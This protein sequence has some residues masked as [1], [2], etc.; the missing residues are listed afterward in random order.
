MQTI[1]LARRLTGKNCWINNINF[2]WRNIGTRFSTPIFCSKYSIW[3]PHIHVKTVLQTLS[4][5]QRYSQYC[6]CLFIRGFFLPKKIFATLFVPFHTRFFTQKRYSQYC[7]CLF[8]RSFFYQKKIVAILFVPFYKRF[9]SKKKIFAIFV[10][11]FHKRVFY[12]KKIVAKLFVPFYKRFF[13]PKK[14]IRNI[15]CAFS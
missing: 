7:L 1:Y 6:W 14:D 2:H 5:S 3:P 11:P 15:F 13:L 12:Q 10:V 8:T 9:F 4:F